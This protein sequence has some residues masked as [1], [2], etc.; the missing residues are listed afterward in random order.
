MTQD[1]EHLRMLSIFHYIVGGLAGLF[2]LIPIVYLLF[3]L[4]FI[5]APEKFASQGAAPPAVPQAFFL[6]F[7]F[8]PPRPPPRRQAFFRS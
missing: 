1:E 3:G 7:R 6:R 4:F 2:A 5:F 8:C